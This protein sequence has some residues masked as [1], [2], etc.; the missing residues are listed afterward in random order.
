MSEPEP[1]FRGVHRRPTKIPTWAAQITVDHRK[2]QLGTFRCP[3]QAARAYDCAAVQ[4]F[5]ARAIL[6]FEDERSVAHMLAPDGMRIA[7]KA[8]EREHRQAERLLRARHQ[9]ED[10]P[11]VKDLLLD[12]QVMAVQYQVF[13]ESRQQRGQGEAGPS[14][15]QQQGEDSSSSLSSCWDRLDDATDTGASRV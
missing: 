7:T 14:G 15:T 9:R 3:W 2:I 4:H 11:L 8:E 10:D 5:G 12:P 1:K 13:S 6:N